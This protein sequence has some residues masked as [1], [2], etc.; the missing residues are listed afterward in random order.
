MLNLRVLCKTYL[1]LGFLSSSLAYA[2]ADQKFAEGYQE[3][4]SEP[5]ET[6][7]KE[8]APDPVAKIRQYL[9]ILFKIIIY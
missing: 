7:K 8:S 3:Q 4:K 6:P 5:A 1:I 9:F 2:Q